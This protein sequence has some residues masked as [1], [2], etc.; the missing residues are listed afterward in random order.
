MFTDKNITYSEPGCYL[1]YKN[2]IAFQFPESDGIEEYNIRISDL[3]VMGN[4]AYYNGGTLAQRIN[5]SWD[6]ADYKKDIIKKRYSNDDQIAIILNKEDSEE[7]LIRYERMMR[8]RE[9]ASRL[10]KAIIKK[11]N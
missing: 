1:K 2:K 10:A 6:Y 5:K 11:I 7:D 3:C 4:I 8:W 9:F